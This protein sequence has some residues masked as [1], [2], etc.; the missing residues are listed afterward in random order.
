MYTGGGVL[1]INNHLGYMEVNVPSSWR[2][3]ISVV[4]ALGSITEP[5]D[6]NSDGPTVLIRGENSLGVLEIKYI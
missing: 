6:S 2:V 4:N 3:A 5:T 1:H